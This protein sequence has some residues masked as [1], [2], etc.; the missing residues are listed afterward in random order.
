[1]AAMARQLADQFK[2]KGS[3]LDDQPA[4]GGLT[5]VLAGLRQLPQ[6]LPDG[7]AAAAVHAAADSVLTL[8]PFSRAATSWTR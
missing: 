2:N 1:M 5:W 3:Q 4:L 7:P 8:P 6:C